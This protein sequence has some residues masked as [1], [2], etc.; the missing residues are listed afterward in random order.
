[1]K[2]TPLLFG[3]LA[4]ASCQ[5]YDQPYGKATVHRLNEPAVAEEKVEITSN[6]AII[7]EEPAP[8][9]TVTAPAI[10]EPAPAPVPEVKKP[11]PKPA[12]APVPAPEVK[13]PEPKPA[14]APAPAPEVKKPAPVAKAP[15]VVPPPAPTVKDEPKASGSWFSQN[16]VAPAPAPKAEAPAA[17]K[18]TPAPAPAPAVT[19]APTQPLKTQAVVAPGATL[20]EVHPDRVVK[21][22]DIKIL[23]TAN[24]PVIVVP[25][26]E[27]RVTPTMPG[28][29]RG[30][31]VRH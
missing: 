26:S 27:K 5:H 14:P 22:G 29:N 28:Q 8:A 23:N 12:S 9:P 3:A 31:R 2:Y 21:T 10:E 15:V 24:G 13:K 19:K 25:K 20:R 16:Q 11:E 17:P 1:M 4:L 7:Y 6:D 30:L 18:A